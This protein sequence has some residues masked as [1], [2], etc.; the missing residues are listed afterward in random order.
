[1]DNE[2]DMEIFRSLTDSDL[3]SLGITAFGAR[4]K[5]LLAIREMA[6]RSN[7]YP[8]IG[9]PRFSVAPG[10]ERRTSSGW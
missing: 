7:Q 1:M 5:L 10:A 8:P 6:S 2:I 4:R 9:T 3:E